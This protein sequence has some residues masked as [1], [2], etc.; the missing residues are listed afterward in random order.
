MRRIPRPL[1]IIVLET[2]ISDC[3]AC[4]QSEDTKL[5]KE[6]GDLAE[7]GGLHI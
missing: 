1:F 3:P 6:P 5:K 2:V 7:E 4:E